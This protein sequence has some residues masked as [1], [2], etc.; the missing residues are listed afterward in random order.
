[1]KRTCLKYI[2]LFVCIVTCLHSCRGKKTSS[3]TA[4]NGVLVVATSS[5]TAAYARAAGAGNVVVLAPFDMVHP[6]EYELRPGDIPLLIDATMIVFAGY[7]VMTERLKKGLN[8][9]AEKLLQINTDYS[10]ESMEKS[11][12]K[13]A[14]KLGT[15]SVAHENLTEIRRIFDDGKK[16]IDAQG[17]TGLPVVVHRFQSS[18][19][20]E[21]GFVP[22]V[23]FGPASPEASEILSVSRTN[24][25]ILID[26]FHNPVGQPLKEVLP[27]AHYTRLLNF[28]GQKGT[29]S[30]A[31]VIRYNI[32]QLIDIFPSATR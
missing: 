11:I 14:A 32:S 29:E 12:M 3:D 4:A 5:W 20:R 6:S 26:N 15:E 13:I 28:P 16:A 21:L 2:L 10:L 24:A 31:G 30:L 1:M 22:V 7:E 25:V 8:I 18:F 27:D 23:V 17:M 19:V 9:P